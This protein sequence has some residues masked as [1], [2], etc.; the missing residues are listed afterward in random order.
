MPTGNLAEFQ[1]NYLCFSW[2]ITFAASVLIEEFGSRE[3][4]RH[5]FVSI[6]ERFSKSTSIM[7]LTSSYICDQEP[8]MVEAFA[9]FTSIFVRCSPKVFV[10]SFLCL[11]IYDNKI[12]ETIIFV[13]VL[14]IYRKNAYIRNTMKP[15][16]LFEKSRFN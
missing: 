14:N 11:Y 13:Q 6:F 16:M 4:Y 1:Y 8:D 9:N 15:D 5:L 10:T 12:N 7:A 3:E 2:S